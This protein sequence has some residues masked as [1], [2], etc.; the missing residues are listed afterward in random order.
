LFGICGEIC[1]KTLMRL[2]AKTSLEVSDDL[3]LEGP[4]ISFLEQTVNVNWPINPF[5][6]DA[7]TAV[8]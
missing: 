7:R 4:K 5:R 8:G 6:I 2:K 3:A 1:R